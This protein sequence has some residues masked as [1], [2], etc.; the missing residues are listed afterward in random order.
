MIAAGTADAEQTYLFAFDDVYGGAVHDPA[1]A[2]DHRLPRPAGDILSAQVAAS[3][4]L[5]ALDDEQLQNRLTEYR[6]T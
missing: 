5:R 3:L 4:S 6:G 2:D 1:G